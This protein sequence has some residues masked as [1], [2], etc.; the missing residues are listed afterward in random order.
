MCLGG[1]IWGI[2][3][4]VH[5]VFPIHWSSNEPILEF[6][7]DL[8]VYNFLMPLAVR[9]FRP[10][11]RLKNMY[12]WWFRKCARILRLT[13]FL[14]G[15][16]QEDEEGRYVNTS[17]WRL[18]SGEKGRL[19]QSTSEGNQQAPG[20]NASTD[21]LVPNGTYVRV[22]ASDQVRIPKGTPTFLEVDKDNHRVDG[23]PDVAIGPHGYGNPMYSKVYIPPL[24]RLRIGAFILLIWMFAA[25]TGVGFT[26]V[27]LIFGR[28]VLAKLIPNH[29]RMNDV[30]AFSIGI[31]LLG[32]PVYLVVRYYN[33]ISSFIRG[34]RQSI[35]SSNPAYAST[36]RAIVRHSIMYILHAFRLLYFYTSFSLLLPSL[37]ALFMELYLII[38]LHTYFSTS[39]NDA[40]ERHT[41]HFIQDWTLGVLYIKTAGRLILWYSNSRPARALLALVA[42]PRG[43]LDPD[44]RLATRAFIFPAVTVMGMALIMP[45]GLGFIVNKTFFASQDEFFK[46]IV[47]RYCY[48]TVLGFVLAVLFAIRVNKAVEGWRLRVRDEV[49]LIGERLH[50][51]GEKRGKVTRGR[52]VRT[53]G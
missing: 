12:G 10:S 50:N 33:A 17:I 15:E 37:F 16:R 40:S 51:F 46:A 3:F 43:W 32:G 13:E 38:P 14:F 48:P 26:I 18:L 9:F 25:T 36:T 19:E 49:Y 39:T 8:L 53:G 22:P 6:P 27:P 34:L 45:L 52:R 5:G 47:Y 4:V 44:I 7:V 41:I 1:V 42:P 20:R 11:K 21:Q 29:L 28:Y 35:Q 31:Y 23:L 30:Y 24:F 2:S